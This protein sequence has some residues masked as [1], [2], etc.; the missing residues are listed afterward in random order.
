MNF[1]TIRKNIITISKKW[2]Q[3]KTNN[4]REHDNLDLKIPF[5]V[6][7]SELVPATSYD[8]RISGFGIFFSGILCVS[9]V[10]LFTL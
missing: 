1:E 9:V 7:K 4:L 5:M 6:S 2:Q 10:I 3:S 8:L